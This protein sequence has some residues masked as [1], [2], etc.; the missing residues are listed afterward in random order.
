MFF[1]N[2]IPATINLCAIIETSCMEGWVYSGDLNREHSNSKLIY[3]ELLLIWYSDGRWL[4]GL[5]HS[6]ISHGKKFGNQMPFG[7]QTFYHL[8]SELL[9]HYSRHGLNNEP[10]EERTVLEHLNTKLVRYSDPH[11]T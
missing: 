4:N 9:V 7:Y 8:I 10:L 11:C 1:C 3:I 6:I 5:D 2:L